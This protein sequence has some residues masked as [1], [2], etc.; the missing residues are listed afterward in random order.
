MYTP[1]ACNRCQARPAD[2][3]RE[4]ASTAVAIGGSGAEVPGGSASVRA[5]RR[6]GTEIRVE[7]RVPTPAVGERWTALFRERA[8]LEVTAV[9]IDLFFETRIHSFL[10]EFTQLCFSL[11]PWDHGEES[12]P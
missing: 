5:R 7:L 10:A 9:D 1:A 4:E 3:S 11:F 12:K 6:V 8:A 2:I